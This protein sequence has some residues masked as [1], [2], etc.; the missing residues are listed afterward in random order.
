MGRGLSFIVCLIGVL[1]FAAIPFSVSCI[2]DEPVVEVF[3]VEEPLPVPMVVEVQDW[4][5]DCIRQPVRKVLD[6]KIVKR[7][8]VQKPVVETYVE[9]TRQRPVRRQPVRSLVRRLF[10]R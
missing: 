10:C 3:E 4:C 2:G 9:V 8:V 5:D 6:R 1:A 7:V